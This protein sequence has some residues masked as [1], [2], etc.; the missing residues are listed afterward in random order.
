[1]W[2]WPGVAL[3]AH[4]RPPAPESVR[5]NPVDRKAVQVKQTRSV[6]NRILLSMGNS[7][8]LEQARGLTSIIE[9]V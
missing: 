4:P 5:L 1:L 3:T 8:R 7:R 2:P 9:T 6:R